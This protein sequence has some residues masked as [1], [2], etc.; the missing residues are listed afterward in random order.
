MPE[1][2]EPY[3]PTILHGFAT[4]AQKETTV[5]ITF[6]DDEDQERTL[7]YRALYR[8]SRSQAAGLVQ[9]GVQPGDLV[10]LVMPNSFD[11]ITAFFAVQMVGAIPVPTYAPGGFNL[12]TAMERMRHIANHA[13]VRWCVT[14]REVHSYLGELALRVETLEQIC[15]VEDL[16]LPN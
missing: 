12:D 16:T 11:F 9:L 6:I 2:L 8:A 5:G 14:N 13:R 3:H 7:S 10:L 4:A 15:C 1:E